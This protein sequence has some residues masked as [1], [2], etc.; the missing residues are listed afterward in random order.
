MDQATIFILPIRTKS[1]PPLREWLVNMATSP[2]GLPD[3]STLFQ[4][5]KRYHCSDIMDMVSI[6][7]L[8]IREKSEPPLREWLVIMDTSPKG[9]LVTC[10]QLPDFSSVDEIWQ[11]PISLHNRCNDYG[12]TNVIICNSGILIY[13]G[14]WHIDIIRNTFR[15]TY[16]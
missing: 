10:H 5:L 14:G 16:S 7:I 8:S 1:E 6:S 13:I 11:V 4:H 3:M 9:L 2:K 12:I 15:T